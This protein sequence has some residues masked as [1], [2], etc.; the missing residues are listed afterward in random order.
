MGIVSSGSISLVDLNDAKQLQLYIGS[1]I[2]KSQ[3]YNS[4]TG[5]YTPNWPTTK[6]VLTP[7]LYVAGS[8]A[9]VISS[10]KTIKW[11]VDGLEITTSTTDYTLAASGVKTL[12]INTNVLAPVIA[13]RFTAEVTYTDPDTLVDITGIADIEFTKLTAASDGSDAITALISNESASI[14]TLADGSGGVFAGAT[15]TISI[16]EGTT[17]VTASWTIAQTRNSVTVTE[18]ASSKTATVTAMS[19]DSGSVVFTATRSGYTTLT[20]TFNLTK[21]KQGVSGA[22]P[23]AYWLV[24]DANVFQKNLANVYSPTSI[25]ISAKSQTGSG[26]PGN[27]SGRFIISDSTDG[28][29][30]TARYT[31]SANEATKNY[32]PSAGIKAIKV[33]MFLANGTTTLVDEQIIPVVSDG[34]TGG[35]GANAVFVSV[36]A[37]DGTVIRNSTGTLTAKADLFSGSTSV[38]G[39]AYKWY[40]Q[41]PT[42]TTASGGDADGGNGWRLLNS[43]TNY[44]TTGYTTATLTI[45]AGAINGLET[46]KCVATYSGVKF[47]DICTFIDVSD[48]IQVV[49]LGNNIFKNGQGTVSITAKLY[50]TQNE[51]DIAGTEY[52]Y[53]WSLYDSFNN[54]VVSFAKTGKTINVLATEISSKATLYC[55]VSK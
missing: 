16:F 46:F 34:A 18:A 32:I 15:S 37:P 14:A 47:T 12:T 25:N 36:W 22:S 30:F 17:D 3:I 29:A 7:Q 20:K 41:D 27:Y 23:T 40:A 5:T 33:Q 54:K 53:A 49:V 19:A 10:A 52:T 35:Q 28:T 11:F 43:T 45:P 42:A 6:P 4:T 38:T 26:A 13:R 39:S 1:N 8:T 44:G 2:Q 50:Q 51:I 21:N 31:S 9:N 55:D 24:T 48:P